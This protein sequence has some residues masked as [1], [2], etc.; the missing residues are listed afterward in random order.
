MTAPSPCD[1]LFSGGIVHPELYLWDAWSYQDAGQWHLY[2]LAVARTLPD[3]TAL[4]AHHRNRVPFHIRH[5]V[6]D[7]SGR[8][9]RDLG[10]F[11]SHGLAP[12]GH[13]ARNVWSG[14]ILRLAPGKFLCG[15]TGLRVRDDRHE[16]F[17]TLG[18]GF[19]RDGL[20]I[21][22]HSL[23]LL[24]CPERDHPAIRDAG[25][26]VDRIENLGANAG[27]ENGPILAWRD[28]FFIQDNGTVYMLWAAKKSKDTC[29]LGMATVTITDNTVAMDKL[30][31]PVVMPDS[32][33][34][35]QLEIPKIVYDSTQA[36]FILIIATTTRISETQPDAEVEKRM[37]LYTAKSITGPWTSGGGQS[38]AIENSTCLFGMTVLEVDTVSGT[39]RC[40]APY[41]ELAQD[42]KPLSFAPTFNIALDDIGRC[43]KIKALW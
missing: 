3:G 35:S 36:R 17:Q 26:Y 28:P 12:D 21:D 40:M 31:P 20:T 33:T 16:F 10:E 8:H 25:Y 34:F 1:T 41:T 2:C 42:P 19:S 11:Q 24:L 39:L 6:S 37:R 27:E 14:S 23:S 22:P 4:A 29:A 9:W 15:Y 43:N 5:F 30:L 7:D 13:D 38:S 18:A 32:A